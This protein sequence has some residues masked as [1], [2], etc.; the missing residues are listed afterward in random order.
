MYHCGSLNEKKISLTGSGVQALDFL[1]VE[2]F[3]GSYGIF[4]R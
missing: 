2:L 4:L 1:W 3:G